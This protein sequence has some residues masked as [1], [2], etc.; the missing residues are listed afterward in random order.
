MNQEEYNGILTFYIGLVRSVFKTLNKITNPASKNSNIAVHYLEKFLNPLTIIVEWEIWCLKL[1]GG[2]DIPENN[3]YTPMK[4]NNAPW[5]EAREKELQ[6]WF[7]RHWLY[8]L[9]DDKVIW[10]GQDL[11]DPTSRY[12][13][14]NR[15]SLKF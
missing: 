11:K 4:A 12:K 14:S 8:E 2:F 10:S 1:E 9:D 13:F 15:T 6:K 7:H 3:I 5:T